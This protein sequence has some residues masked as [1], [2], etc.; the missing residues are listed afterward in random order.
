[1]GDPRPRLAARSF[2]SLGTRGVSGPVPE[3]GA[4][5]GLLARGSKGLIHGA[6]LLRPLGAVTDNYAGPALPQ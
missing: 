5:P 4:G 6:R 1:M 3:R 2:L